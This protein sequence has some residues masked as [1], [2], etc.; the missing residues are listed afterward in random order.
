[1]DQVIV[2]LKAVDQVLPIH[3]AQLLSYVKLSGCKVGLLINFKVKLLKEGVRRFVNLNCAEIHFLC[4]LRGL[5]GS[6]CEL[7][8]TCTST[9]GLLHRRQARRRDGGRRYEQVTRAFRTDRRRRRKCPT[10]ASTSSIS[11]CTAVCAGFTSTAS[12]AVAIRRATLP[13][14][15]TSSTRATSSRSA[16]PSLGDSSLRGPQRSAS[17]RQ[18][19]T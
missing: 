11:A 18:R 3:E 4:G 15:P 2:E 1:M 10:S 9:F 16:S 7:P 5:C 6:F 19:L 13:P 12:R 14:W 17:R 8:L